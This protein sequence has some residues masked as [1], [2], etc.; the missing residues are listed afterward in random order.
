MSLDPVQS[1]PYPS[2][3]ASFQGPQKPVHV[4]VDLTPMLPGG[5]NGGA[6]WVI[7]SLLK[8]WV[9]Q[10]GSWRWTLLTT[11]AND[12]ALAEQF[13]TMG[14]VRV[15]DERGAVILWPKLTRLPDGSRADLLFAP[16]G[17]PTHAHPAVP[18]VSVVYDLQFIE[19][20]QFFTSAQLQERNYNF[21]QAVS[22]A[23]RLICG[24]DYVKD[25]ILRTV[26][27]DPRRLC[28]V[29][30][31]MAD[32]LPR[33]DPERIPALAAEMGLSPGRYLIYPANTWAHKNHLML[34]T[35]AGLYFSA[36]R[37]SDLK[38][39]CVGTGES[40]ARESL[41]E[42][43]R[44]MGLEDRF[45]LPGFLSEP[46]LAA[47]IAGAKALIYPSLFEGFGMPVLEAMGLGVPVLVSNR[48]SL[49]E[50]AGDA[51]LSFDPRRPTEIVAAITT[52]ED[53]PGLAADLAERS[54]Q[55][56]FALGNAETMARAYLDVFSEVVQSE[57][58]LCAVRRKARMVMQSVRPI[59]R[60]VHHIW[61]AQG[62]LG[63]T[64][65]TLFWLGRRPKIQEARAAASR[66]FPILR[67]MARSL[68]KMLA[69]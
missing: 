44:L 36:R 4:V 11:A 5:E 17:A 3:P 8:E 65:E 37:G 1:S 19:Y 21:R 7:L 47:L 60:T 35:A 52:L 15:L 41:R 50:V 29:H 31:S 61:R 62:L 59:A 39:V 16:F 56:A 13:P 48:T 12:A 67:S 64:K 51:A 22:V 68:W 6:K 55:R 14:R 58:R 53:S 27:L 42:A 46:D 28:R 32:R 57:R 40:A 66:R 63:L 34:L 54:R 9:K 30:I 23:Q 25:H 69:R 10:A 43:T 38:F 2:P 45:L 24:S 18:T 49:P 20:P 33:P 26:P